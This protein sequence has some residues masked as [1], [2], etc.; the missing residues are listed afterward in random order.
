MARTKRSKSN[1]P[2][3][4]PRLPITVVILRTAIGMAFFLTFLC[5][6]LASQ[7]DLETVRA[8]DGQAAQAASADLASLL[9]EGEPAAASLA[10]SAS[11]DC[12]VSQ[13]FPAEVRQWCDLITQNANLYG[14]APNLVAA[15]IWFES[16]GNP[17]AYSH[18]GA[19]GLMQVMPR[20]GLAASFQCVNGPCFAN[21]PTR[22]ELEDPAFNIE[23]GVRMLANLFERTQSWR[24][25]LH[26]YGPMD[27]GYS[28]ADRVLALY[29]SYDSE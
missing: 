12:G 1:P 17:T 9:P 13:S 22:S 3:L 19:T 15:V 18:S 23:Y 28:Y 29:A 24:E 10:E 4:S 26:A 27:V 21:R 6:G 8:S 14:L 20:D 5:L 25:A 2:R 11:S 7:F 16:G